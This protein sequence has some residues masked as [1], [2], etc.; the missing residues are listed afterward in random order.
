MATLKLS[1]PVIAVT[2]SSGKTTT[3]EMIASVLGT[4][5]QV[6]KS[7]ENKNLFGD[8]RSYARQIRPFHQAVVLEYG[9]IYRG[10]IKRHCSYIQPN[11]GIITMVGTAHIGNMGGL[12]GLIRAKSELIQ[13]MDPHGT[14]LLNADNRNSQRLIFGVFKGRVIRIGINQKADYM[15][16]GIR[17]LPQGM[18]FKVRLGGRIHDFFIPCHGQHNVY[19]ALFAIAVAHRL[20]FDAAHIKL[21]LRRFNQPQRRLVVHHCDNGI[22][23][24]DDTFSS[25]PH[26]VEAALDVLQQ[27]GGGRKIAIL[28]TM[29]ELGKLTVS[30]HK[31]VGRYLA[32]KKVDFLEAYGT[33]A[34]LIG[35]GA[36]EAGYAPERINHFLIRGSL[37]KHVLKLIRPGST[38]LVKGSHDLRM[39][40]TVTYLRARLKGI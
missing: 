40:Q 28:G 25:N 16:S 21:G 4:R 15:A 5:W 22:R 32:R 34:D 11:I 37:H 10:R 17:H 18:S 8:T 23:I 39:D 3:K 29:L 33:H 20:G 30:G 38:V 27:V 35:K 1:R 7:K 12:D 13:H 26:A 6:F 31:R 14:L 19:N 2:G 24:I 9:M 36:V